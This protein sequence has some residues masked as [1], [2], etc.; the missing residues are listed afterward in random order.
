MDLLHVN[1]RRGEYP[2][3]F[4]A[5]TRTPIDPFPALQGEVRADVA[6]VGGEA[7][8]VFAPPVVHMEKVHQTLRSRCS[9]S[10]GLMT[11][12]NSLYSFRFTES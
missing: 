8:G 3:S 6:V 10:H 2:A 9:R 12:R 11:C 4:Y 7:G 1:D 5:A